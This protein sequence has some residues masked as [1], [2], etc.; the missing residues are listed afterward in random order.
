MSFHRRAA[1]IFLI[2]FAVRLVHVWQLRASPYFST[3]LG[4]SRGYDT[5]ARQLAAGDW[6]GH[7][8]FYQAPL[9]PYFLGALYALFGRDLLMV[10]VVQ[11]IVGSGACVLLGLTAAR[12]FS[13]RAGLIAGLALAVYAPAIFLD[14]LI[15][16]STLDVFFVCVALWLVA[17]LVAERAAIAKTATLEVGSAIGKNVEKG[18]VP[19][20]A[21]LDSRERRL[22]LALG[23]VLGALTLTRE[24]AM[25]MAAVGLAWMIAPT[26]E[27]RRVS[28]AAAAR[29][30]AY[31]LA[32]S[33]A[34]A[35]VAARNAV[36]GG[37]FYLTTSQFGSNL[38]IGNNAR[39]TGTYMGLRE[40]R[41]SPAFERTDATEIAEAAV[42]HPLTPSQVSGFWRSRAIEFITSQPGD[43]LR[44]L[45][46]KLLL[47]S[48]ATEMIDTE[49]QESHAEWSLPIRLTAWIGHFGV[50]LPLAAF[51]VIATWRERRDLWVVHAMAVAYAASVLVFFVVARY[52]YP[53]IPFAILFAAAGVV[54]LPQY[55]RQTPRSRQIIALAVA[56]GVAVLAQWRVETGDMMKAITETNLALALS[57]DGRTDEA[58]GHYRRALAVQPDYA[59]AANNLGVAL[60]ASGHLDDAI[61][62]FRHALD[63]R[64]DYA[65]AHYN[66]A[67]ALLDRNEPQEAA[68]H[69]EIASHALSPTLES[70]NNY[71]VALAAGGR[72]DEAIAQFTAA[73]ALEP[74][75]AKVHRNIADALARQH[76]YD[77]AIE[78]YRRV[79]ELDR[80][81][82][83]AYY[84]LG[85]VLLE[86]G[87][88]RDA[89]EAFRAAIALAPDVAQAHT[90]LGIALAAQ[91][92]LDEAI[93]AFE[94]ALKLAPDFIDARRYLTIAREQRGF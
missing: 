73:L 53:L 60:R 68:T 55:F 90:K 89:A 9:Y 6:M 4:D 93:E 26:F 77:D 22:S 61:E 46:R 80:R 72:L 69:F 25:A 59:P 86:A 17:E 12:L 54:A 43:W 76:R 92:K 3:L 85:G 29:V 21:V 71:G 63:V 32:L 2:A 40:G 11:A 14:G 58:V 27:W 91:G 15:Q 23:L 57:E 79:T 51:G 64:S 48:S 34:L 5:W 13:V 81:N 75:S 66:L 45:G 20:F 8:V 84:E 65:E 42:G 16:K 38:F 33:L 35:P 52:R 56:L 28:P 18:T 49:S 83:G 70:H 94:R 44:L 78:H 82:P 24:N 36:V 39:A 7:D 1:L 37:G 41:E 47:L 88:L 87:R 10:R 67:I 30:V 50:L 31:A 74:H 62:S 19:F